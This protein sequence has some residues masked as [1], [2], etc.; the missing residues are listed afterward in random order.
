[1]ATLLGRIGGVLGVNLVTQASGWE[2]GGGG[3]VNKG[4]DCGRIEMDMLSPEDERNCAK[5]VRLYEWD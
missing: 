3:M 4:G 1:M 2:R 5:E